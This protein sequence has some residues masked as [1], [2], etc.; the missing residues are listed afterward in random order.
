MDQRKINYSLLITCA[1]TILGWGVTFGICQ[2]KIESN[3]REIERLEQKLSK[4]ETSLQQINSQLAALNA[5][6]DLL[7]DGRI[8][9][10]KE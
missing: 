2:N 8:L 6:M 9:T 3:A 4:T 1:V 7:L 10:K 5:K